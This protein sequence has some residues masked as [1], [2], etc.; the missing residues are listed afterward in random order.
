MPVFNSL[1]RLVLLAVITTG[2]LATGCV[3]WSKGLRT[4]DETV[5]DWRDFVWGKRAYTRRYGRSMS[6]PF[7]NGFLE[8]Y[9]D[10]LQGGDGCLPVVPPKK[11]WGWRYQSAGGQS[12][13]SDWFDGYA[14]GVQAAREDGL[15]NVSRIPTSSNFGDSCNMPMGAGMMGSGMMSGE[16]GSGLKGY[17]PDEKSMMMQPMR[18]DTPVPDAPIQSAPIQRAPSVEPP[19]PAK[20][21]SFQKTNQPLSSRNTGVQ[22]PVSIIPY[23]GNSF[24]PVPV[25][26]ASPR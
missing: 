12:S 20:K 18:M 11:Y 6:K 19:S 9:H 2:F 21:T 10:M 13:I 4:V 22:T 25:V 8:G 17:V 14:S 16:I 3:P 5:T 26:P 7:M 15:A 23:S 1:Q 24:N